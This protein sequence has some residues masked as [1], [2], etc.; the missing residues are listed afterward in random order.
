MLT[1]LYI[2]RTRLSDLNFY[3][4]KYAKEKCRTGCGRPATV[5]A[6]SPNAVLSIACLIGWPRRAYGQIAIFSNLP[7][8]PGSLLRANPR[9]FKSA[10][11]TQSPITGKSI[12]TCTAASPLHLPRRNHKNTNEL[13]ILQS[14][15]IK[16]ART[17]GPDFKF[18]L[19]RLRY[20]VPDCQ[21]LQDD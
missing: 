12:S 15:P 8:K 1:P 18:N 3:V 16:K 4:K 20:Q 19:F 5:F 11:K 14:R 2:L 7:V 21:R 6:F 9:F 13:C 10:R 17:Q